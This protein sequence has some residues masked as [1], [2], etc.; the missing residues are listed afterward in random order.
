MSGN[1]PFAAKIVSPLKCNEKPWDLWVSEI[2]HQSPRRDDDGATFTAPAAVDGKTP[3]R[4]KERPRYRRAGVSKHKAPSHIRPI[5]KL[6]VRDI[7]DKLQEARL[8]WYGQIARRPQSLLVPDA[9]A[10]TGTK[11]AAQQ[12]AG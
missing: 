10:V 6:S 2:G 5:R 3:A 4:R 7:G 1:F 8:R 9:S 11:I 12:S